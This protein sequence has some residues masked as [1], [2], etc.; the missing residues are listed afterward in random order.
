MIRTTESHSQPACR[1][2][3]L[4]ITGTAWN[5]AGCRPRLAEHLP[6]V[7]YE[8]LWLLV[9]REVSADLMLRLEHDLSFGAQQ[10]FR[11]LN[12][13]LGEEGQA[14]RNTRLGE[15]HH[16]IRSLELVVDP[17]GRCGPGTREP[18]NRDPREY[19][20]VGPRDELLVYPRQQPDGRVGQ[21]EPERLR[22]S[23]LFGKVAHAILEE[24]FGNCYRLS[25]TRREGRDQALE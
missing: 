22:L 24:V 9:C 17:N 3:L 18:I 25:L 16:C 20:V 14:D 8:C 12:Y 19:F 15:S 1:F 13:L 4:S 2:K 21:A 5:D 7:T 11:R 10:S 6:K 23:G